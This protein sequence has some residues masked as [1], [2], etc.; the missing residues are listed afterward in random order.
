MEK[1]GDWQGALEEYRAA[2]MIDPRDTFY[3]QRYERLLQQMNK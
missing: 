3:K 2:Y 1:K